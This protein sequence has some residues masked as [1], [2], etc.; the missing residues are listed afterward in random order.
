[1]SRS[2]Q[3]PDAPARKAFSQF[4]ATTTEC[5]ARLPQ[6]VAAYGTDP[7]RFEQV[8]ATTATLVSE[9]GE[10]A[11]QCRRALGSEMEPA[12]S[13]VYLRRADLL[14]LVERYEAVAAATERFAAELDAVGPALSPGVRV[15]LAQIARMS[16]DAVAGLERTAVDYVE[17]L[18][19]DAT[20]GV[21]TGIERVRSLEAE[22]DAV[23]GECLRTAFG[24][25]TCEGEALVVK[26]LLDGLDAVPDAAGDAARHLVYVASKNA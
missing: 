22:C 6:L 21:E 18:A 14:E 8:R 25:E 7:E 3:A 23:R 11:L 4:A 26:D 16:H 2:D 9:V 15:G 5:A 24:G 19:A 13:R 1:M 20:P 17:A 12:F 10:L